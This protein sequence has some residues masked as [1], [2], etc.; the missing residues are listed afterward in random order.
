MCES[1]EG[2]GQADLELGPSHQIV[3]GFDQILSGVGLCSNCRSGATPLLVR[4][5]LVLGSFLEDL[6]VGCVL[7]SGLTGL[8]CLG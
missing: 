3:R 8:V 6:T 7:H 5:S 4:T 2:F 1:L